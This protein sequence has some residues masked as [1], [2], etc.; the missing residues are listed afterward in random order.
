[1]FK[2]SYVPPHEPGG[3]GWSIQQLTLCN[4]YTQN[5][6]LQN[7]WTVSNK[8]LNLCRFIKSKIVLYRQ[9]KTD[10]IFTY[11]IEPPYDVSKYYYASHHPYKML[12][13]KYRI[14]VP[15]FQTAPHDKRKYIKKTIGPP[16]QIKNEWY[17]Q[18]QFC[19]LPLLEF[20]CTACSLNS[21]Y[22]STKAVNNNVT[23]LSINTRFFQNPRFQYP[24]TAGQGY[25]PKGNNPPYLY[26]CPLLEP[27]TASW[28][29]QKIAG[30]VV[31]LGD[32]MTND[33]GHPIQTTTETT[34]YNRLQW[35]NPFYNRYLDNSMMTFISNC[36]LSETITKKNETISSLNPQIT[37]EPFII[38]CR[39]NPYKDK[40]TS[41]MAYWLSNL[42]APN[43]D[44]P[45]DPDLII[46]GFPL[47]IL[48]WGW[49]EFT[50]KINKIRIK[51]GNYMLVIRSD[52]FDE[53]L[54]AYVLV[55]DSWVGGFAPYHRPPSEI[56]TND[57]GHWYPRWKFQEEAIQKILTTGPAVCKN[58]SQDSVQAHF[59]Y[60]LLFKWGGN[61]AT[62]ENVYDPMSQP[63]YPTPNYQQL[64][65]EI[66]SPETS[67]QNYIYNFDT[68]RDFLTQAATKRIKEIESDD[69]SLFSDG[70]QHTTDAP[71]PFKTTPQE[72]PTS[73]KEKE[74]TLQ[75]QLLLVQ[76]Y[77]SQLRHKLRR[78]TQIANL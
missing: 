45:K 75:Q 10:Y 58:E 51:S 48:L 6:Y 9:E 55:S 71:L 42:D 56:S 35:G 15:S 73:E 18:Q 61:P 26:G 27:L 2:E 49:Q 14:V 77:N 4:L 63:I 64:Q 17:F 52:A 31:Y 32:T 20:A 65:T 47:W 29:N 8:G 21:M 44:P 67:I 11:R 22:M 19:K 3:G 57:Y 68:K 30:N 12:L 41:N 13:S 72:T 43:W 36:T 74:T 70:A 16:R 25:T 33:E 1:M 60:N 28:K 5:Q 76:Q 66:T 69:E 39:Y 23:V 37:T 62:M 53:K 78:L 40:G 38:Q 34:Q 24:M 54:P 7:W 50:E 59:K 46:Q